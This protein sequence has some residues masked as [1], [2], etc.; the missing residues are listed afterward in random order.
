MRSSVV[1]LPL[2]DDVSNRHHTANAWK[3]TPA[4]PLTPRALNTPPAARAGTEF[5]LRV[6]YL[7]VYNEE[8]NDLLAPSNGIEGRNLK[9]R[10]P[11]FCLC[12]R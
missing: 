4:L 7:E 10:A 11:M 5:L 2:R 1:S 9:V 3:H 8:I 6:C 12:R